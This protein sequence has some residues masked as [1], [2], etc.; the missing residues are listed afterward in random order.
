MQLYISM[1]SPCVWW[2]DN[3]HL[4]S[5]ILLHFGDVTAQKKKKSNYGLKV[6]WSHGPCSDARKLKGDIQGPQNTE[7]LIQISG[8]LHTTKTVRGFPHPINLR[9]SANQF[10]LD[11]QVK[12]LYNCCWVRTGQMKWR[13]AWPAPFAFIWCNSLVIDSEI[14]KWEAN[15]ILHPILSP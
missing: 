1:L 3:V 5:N 6:S 8:L 10:W 2:R 11:A 14:L 13:P 9:T 15:S 12:G 7:E 4:H